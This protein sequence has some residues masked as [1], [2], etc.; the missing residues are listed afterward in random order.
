MFYYYYYYLKKCQSENL[1]RKIEDILIEHPLNSK[2]ENKKYYEESIE[3]K[4]EEILKEENT[5]EEEKS[6]V[7]RLLRRMIDEGANIKN[8]NEIIKISE[9]IEEES[10]KNIKERELKKDSMES[11]EKRI[12]IEELRR[13]YDS[14]V[15][16]QVSV[17]IMER[18][19]KKNKE[20]KEEDDD[21]DVNMSYYLTKRNIKEERRKKTKKNKEKKKNVEIIVKEI[22]EEK[23]KDKLKIE[24]I[25]C[26]KERRYFVNTFDFL[27]L[28]LIFSDEK[29]IMRRGCT[30]IHNSER[31]W[32]SCV[33]NKELKNVFF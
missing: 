28:P 5:K 20:R 31:N 17:E 4:C 1:Q 15:L 9:E 2:E 16:F 21:D 11:N 3:N 22:K 33:I 19:K 29:N 30:I 27:S 23:E 8:L 32:E 24:N 7:L 18:K 13:L 25:E 10:L 14:S 6:N 26:I 12:K